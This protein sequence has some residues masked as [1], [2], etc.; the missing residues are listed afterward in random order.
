MIRGIY[1]SAT[2]MAASQ[3]LMDVLAGN[4]AN[5]STTGF[6][7]DGLAFDDMFRRQILGGAGLGASIG[8]LGS[9]SALYEQFTDMSMGSVKRTGNPLDVAFTGQP[10][11]FGV[12]TPNGVAYTRDGAFAVAVGSRPDELALVNKFGLP[13]LD[14]SQ[15]PITFKK[16]EVKIDPSGQ[17]SVDGVAG[18]KIGMFTG[19]FQKSSEGSGIFHSSD[20]TPADATVTIQ[21]GALE[22]SNVNPIE[23]MVTMIGIQRAFEMGQKTIQ[24]QDEETQKLFSLLQGQ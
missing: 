7:Q 22:G 11:M 10:G 12:Q 18:P 5:A 16:G 23:S 1:S 20:A 14:G 2:G 4:L 24:S 6:K 17:I 21:Q 15:Q 13:V 8:F 19:N 3:R 9:G